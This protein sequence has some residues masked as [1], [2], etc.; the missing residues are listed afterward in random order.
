MTGDHD[1]M[2]DPGTLTLDQVTSARIKHQRAAQKLLQRIRALTSCGLEDIALAR[3]AGDAIT[4]LGACWQ[5][6]LQEAATLKVYLRIEA[7][8]RLDAAAGCGGGTGG[9]TW[10]TTWPGPC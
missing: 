10:T 6:L 2:A 1:R 3:D 9:V 8:L 7:A 5:Q 4:E